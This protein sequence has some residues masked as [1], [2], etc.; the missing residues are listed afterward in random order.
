MALIDCWKV[1]DTAKRRVKV[2][3][4]DT[5]G[6]LDIYGGF[7]LASAPTVATRV[8]SK[9]FFV[10]HRQTDDWASTPRSAFCTMPAA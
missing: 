1:Y 5:V 8:Q 3:A 6:N 4:V 7:R 10:S 9:L 2:L